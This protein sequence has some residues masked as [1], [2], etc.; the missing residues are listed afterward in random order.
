MD[1][2]KTLFLPIMPQHKKRFFISRIV[3]FNETVAILNA[4]TTEKTYCVVRHEA[5]RK[6]RLKP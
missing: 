4:N 6:E 3:V 5:I 1:L 2:R